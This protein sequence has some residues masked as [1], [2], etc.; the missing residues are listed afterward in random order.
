MN[1]LLLAL[2]LAG[3]GPGAHGGA[4]TSPAVSLASVSGRVTDPDGNPVP[5]VRITILEANRTTRTDEAGHYVLAGLGRGTYGLSFARIGFAPRVVRL[6]VADRDTVVDVVLQPSLVE[7]PDLQVTASPLATT[8]L[9]SPQ[10]TSV[11]TAGDLGTAGAPSLGETASV[12]PGVRSVS[13]GAGIGK[14]VIRGLG[15]NRVLVLAD[16]QRLETQQWGDEHGPN[17]ETADAERVEVIRGPASVLYGSD[18]LGGVINVVDRDLPDAV[19][20]A[21]FVRGRA[22]AAFASNARMPEGTLAVEGAAEGFGFRVSGTGR[23]SGDVRTPAG[24]LANSAIETVGGDASAGL[25][26]VW[27]AAHLTYARRDERLELHEDPAEEPDA[28]PFQRIR[29]D[30]LHLEMTLPLAGAHLDLDA[31]WERNH[32]REFEEAGAT[33]LALGLLS[34]TT[35]LD[36]RLHHSPLGPLD[37]IVGVS[38]LR[39]SV[40]KSGEETLVPGSTVDN[41][42]IFVS[43]QA[44]LGR[45]N[46]SFGA[47]FDHRRLDVD[48]DAELGVEAQRRTYDA[49]SGSVGFLFN[50]TSATAVV[51]NVGRGFRAPSPF[52]LFANGVH[53]GTA[54]FERGD[55]ALANEHSLN[56]D[57]AVRVQSNR[58]SAELGGFLNLVENYIYPRPTG[59]DD[60]ESGFQIFDYTQGNARLYG[61]EAAGEYHPT[62]S[63]HLRATG[64]YVRGQ[65][66]DLDIPLAF[67]PPLRLTYSARLEGEAI[68][69]IAGPYVAVQ[70]E[71]HTRQTH[72]DPD[73]VVT[74]P[75]TLVHAGG[76]FSIPLAGRM[77]GVDVQARNLFDRSYRGFLSRYKTW[78]LDPGRNVI[79]RIGTTF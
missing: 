39:T 71:S 10:P 11:L 36:L 19:G 6:R 60:A 31:G 66:R 7:L 69:A 56:M 33:D 5:A 63:L 75:Y 38:G 23:S 74:D 30:R 17:V 67:I 48:A 59:V 18:A 27:G 12:M 26:G 13:T 37:G 79:V 65:N 53:E 41:G 47:R 35:T 78:A 72:P 4:R 21:P 61:I 34:R 52:E 62:A 8:A 43:E 9:N 44:E 24:P 46:L 54:R 51:L 20:K 45:V 73:D 32:R 50:P 15:S 55:P 25:R 3:A 22:R 76:G 16:G 1:M 42:A 14:P 58:V 70:G 2:A 57:L 77:I 68:G 28:T 40:E 49:V 64:D 29:E